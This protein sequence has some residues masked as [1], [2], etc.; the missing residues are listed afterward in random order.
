MMLFYKAW[1]ESR[2]RFLAGTLALA[3]YCAF[4]IFFRPEIQASFPA[5]LVDASFGEYMYAQFFSGMGKLLF[6]ALAII[7]GLGGLLRERAHRTAAFT[8]ALPVSRAQFVGAQVCVGL[9]ELALLAMLPA[10]L[11]PPL[12]AVVHQSYPVAEVSRYGLLRFTC[13]AEIFA[14]SYF[15]SV[16]LRWEYTAPVACFVALGLQ[17]RVSGWGPLRPYILNLLRALDGRWDWHADVSQINGPLPWTDLS[18]MMLIVLVLLAAATG[19]TQRQ[20]L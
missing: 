20:N 18:T 10:L 12:S 3:G 16:V 7:L 17:A 6:V 2:A 15:L 11:I 1:R 5:R 9:A 13:G 19:I 4:V 8:L 14:M